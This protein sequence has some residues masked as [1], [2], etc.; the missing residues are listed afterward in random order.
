M[1]QVSR[2][3]IL[4]SV[5]TATIFTSCKKDG[6]GVNLTDVTIELVNPEGL[7]SVK[8]TSATL[9]F[10]ETN[11]ST[12]YNIPNVKTQTVPVSVA[13]GSYDISVEGEIT[14]ELNGEV[15]TTNV[16]GIK[17][18]QVVVDATGKI[19]IQLYVYN[20]KADFVIKEVFFTGTVTPEGKTYNGDKYVIIHNNSDKVLY[21]DGLA[22]AESDFLT[23]TKREYFPDVMSEAVTSRFIVVVP[24]TGTQYPIQPGKSFTIANNAI[25]HLEANANSVDLRNA[26]FEIDLIPT[27]NVDNPQVPNTIN[28]SDYLTMHNRGFKAYVLTR[29]NKTVDVF[30]TENLYKNYY[31]NSAGNNTYTDSYKLP[32]AQI[33]DA[34]NLSVQASYEWNVTSPSLDMGWSYCGKLASDATRYGKAVI[35]KTLSTTPD[36]RV[37][38]QDTNNSTNDFTPEAKPSLMK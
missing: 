4:L 10:K 7:V 16:R 13:V 34:V 31:V 36:G 17:Q 3:F 12:V 18:S 23:T 5:I 14:Y 30:K 32:N 26:E 33:L 8:L 19:E 25:N 37:I 6:D 9:S 29:L 35:R 1:K 2:I 38:L 28:V 15:L 20:E 27:I 21:A 11:T 22:F 24:G